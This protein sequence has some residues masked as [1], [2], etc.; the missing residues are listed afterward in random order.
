M[1]FYYNKWKKFFTISN[2]KDYSKVSLGLGLAKGRL[3]NGNSIQFGRDEDGVT[4]VV[5]F[6]AE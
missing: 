5:A 2:R 3:R 1:D 4:A 6:I